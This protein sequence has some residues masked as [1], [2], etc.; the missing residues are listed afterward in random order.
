MVLP[1][2]REKWTG[3]IYE[4]KIG[5]TRGRAARGTESLQWEANPRFRYLTFEGATSEQACD[6]GVCRGYSS[7]LAGYAH[8]KYRKRNKLASGMGC[9]KAWNSSK[10]SLSPFVFIGAAATSKKGARK[11]VRKSPRMCLA[12]S[13]CRSSSGAAATRRSTI[14]FCRSVRAL[15]AGKIV[16]S[17]LQR[18]RITRPWSQSAKR[19]NTSS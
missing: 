1:D 18:K 16:F 17:V 5:A 13:R 8:E 6:S 12:Q 3:S 15:R 2:I 4:V 10:Q 19:I 9:E 11:S 7:G 14:R